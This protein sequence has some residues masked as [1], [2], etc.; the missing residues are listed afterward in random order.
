MP[1]CQP[2]DVN[3]A[4]FTSLT[5]LCHAVRPVTPRSTVPSPFSLR[6]RAALG[7]MSVRE[8]ARRLAGPEATE[9]E[10]DIKRRTV[11]RWLSSETWNPPL[12]A[13]LEAA[14]VLGIDPEGFVV[15]D[16]PIMGVEFLEDLVDRWL[17]LPP[18]ERGQL[19][20]EAREL[21]AALRLTAG[22]AS[23]V[24]DRLEAEAEGRSDVR[25]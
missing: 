5:P 11:N 22:L 13:Q 19:R 7:D 12:E 9:K 18:E 4:T 6:L 15:K 25:A 14:A 21:V 24:A 1:L 3:A 16:T 10:R 8:F 23:Q 20:E 17:A 2:W